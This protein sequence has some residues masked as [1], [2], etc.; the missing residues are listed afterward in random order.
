MLRSQGKDFRLRNPSCLVG[1]EYNQ[2]LRR[3]LRMSECAEA[4]K[5]AEE[6][7]AGE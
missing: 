2:L 5:I 6:L 1:K 4:A 3:N 7:N